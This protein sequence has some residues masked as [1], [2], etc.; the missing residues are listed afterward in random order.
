MT[1]F[2][3]CPHVVLPLYTHLAI[4]TFHQSPM[5]HEVSNFGLC[6]SIWLRCSSP[7]L[8]QDP[9]PMS[10]PLYDLHRQKNLAL[11][12]F[13]QNYIHA[14]TEAWNTV[15]HNSPFNYF[16]AL[17]KCALLKGRPS[18]WHLGTYWA[19]PKAGIKSHQLHEGYSMARDEAHT[20][21]MEN[22]FP[23]PRITSGGRSWCSGTTAEHPATLPRNPD[24][25][26]DG[27]S[28]PFQSRG[29]V[30]FL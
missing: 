28:W 19:R 10:L 25:T 8:P 3:P 1:I 23:R 12:G 11:S 27:K 7:K 21:A 29:N 5:H 9:C 4:Y 22:Q 17:L 6:F 16:S 26:V 15:N 20:V 18:P 30:L 24:T 13:P 2:S 14:S